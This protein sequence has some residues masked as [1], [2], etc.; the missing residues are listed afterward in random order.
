[1]YT[2]DQLEAL[3]A[4]LDPLGLP[5]ACWIHRGSATGQRLGVLSASFNPLTNAHIAIVERARSEYELDEVLLV[6]AKANVD[7][8]VFGA[9]LAERLDML[10]HYCASH[11]HLSLAAASHGRFADKVIALQRLY[12]QNTEIFFMLGYDTLVR[13]FDP[14][15]YQDRDAELDSLFSECG[16]IAV[17]RDS[18]GISAIEQ[19]MQQPENR[20]HAAGIHPLRLDENHARMS[21]SRVRELLRTGEAVE[22]LVPPEI[23]IYLRDHPVYVK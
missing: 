15:Y 13:L 23:L 22:H 2:L 19:L 7:K 11:P 16:F 4:E 1:M 6:L 18:M 9:T 10:K 14:K 5:K 8:Q 21:S 3:I 17:N 12:P 20:R